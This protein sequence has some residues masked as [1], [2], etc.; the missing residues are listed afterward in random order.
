[1]T[2]SRTKARAAAST[3][4]FLA[5]GTTLT[6]CGQSGADETAGGNGVLRIAEASDPG[7]T[8]NPYA[9]NGG[10]TEQMRNAQLYEGLTK[11]GPDGKLRWGLAVSMKPNSSLTRWTIKLRPNVRFTDGSR[12]TAKDVIASIRYIIEPSH[13]AQ[14]AVYLKDIDPKKLSSPDPLTV[15]VGLRHPYGLFE[16]LWTNDLLYMTK[17]GSV[18]NRPIGTGPFASEHFTAGQQ[19]TLARY[20]D[21]WGGPAK[22]KT[23]KIVEFQTQQGQVNA[24]EGGQV[25][26]ASEASPV[27]AKALEHR[28]GIDLLVDRSSYHLLISFNTAKPPFNDP[29]VRKAMRLIVDRRQ[30]VSNALNGFGRVANDQEGG[31]PECPAPDSPQR[32]QDL[33]QAKRLLAQANQRHLSFSIA[34]DAAQPAMVEYIEIFAVQAAKAGVHV[35]VNQLSTPQLLA[36]WD[37]WPSYIDYNEGPYSHTVA[38]NLVPGGVGNATHWNNRKFVGL[39]KQL[40]ATADP[41]TQCRLE[42]EMHRIE[43]QD[44][45]SIIPAWLD[46]V[47]PHRSNVHGLVSDVNGMPLQ[48]LTNV[49]VGH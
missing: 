44:D 42:N 31:T 2:R 38:G 16:Q 39:A 9:S 13:A 5:A 10:P 25:D 19:S 22:V 43:W 4:V 48:F 23:V 30:I 47:V 6:G 40:F 34:T 12:F 29:R 11:L 1:M 37:E 24:L 20:D 35:S 49:T 14:G 17:A 15:T 8:L 26:I 3:V 36:H 27:I 32:K 33:A 41:A 28:D 46:V 45:G 18:P 21:Y 7:E